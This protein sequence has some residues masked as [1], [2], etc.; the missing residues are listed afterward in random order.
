MFK[1][2]DYPLDGSVVYKQWRA[3]K[4]STAVAIRDITKGRDIRASVYLKALR[5]NEL[6]ESS[7]ALEEQVMD[8]QNRLITGARPF[9]EDERVATWKSSFFRQEDWG[10]KGRWKPL[11]FLG[12]SESGKSWK[13]LSLFPHET[14][15]LSC[16]GL[17]RGVMPSLK[18]FNRL[19]H[20]ALFFDEIRPDIVLANREFFQSPAYKQ[21]LGV[22]T[23]G[24]HEYAVWMYGIAIIM[25]A[26]EF[27]I[28]TNYPEAAADQSWLD[29]NIIIA[30]VPAG[31]KWYMA[32]DVA[33]P[34]IG[35][36]P[37]CPSLEDLQR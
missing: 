20:K 2:E 9:L 10:C 18:E 3:H 30:P 13:A 16:N 26:N 31:G 37:H 24:Q 7:L 35:T 1:S 22:S 12:A 15:K 32:E 25:A 29:C 6:A 14:L 19:K 8:V 36:S 34:S 11:L 4:I 28:K 21:K 5:E 17:G 33:K 27:S 23:C